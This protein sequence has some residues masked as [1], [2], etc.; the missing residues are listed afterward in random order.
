MKVILYR[1]NS[2][3]LPADSY[4]RLDS[5]VRS[6]GFCYLFSNR[7]ETVTDTQPSWLGLIH[8]LFSD[9]SLFLL[10]DHFKET[11]MDGLAVKIET[12]N[13]VW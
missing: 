9:P 13:L 3:I 10:P 12:Q 8:S 2:T 6:L 11:F 5:L 1:S 7:Q 4:L